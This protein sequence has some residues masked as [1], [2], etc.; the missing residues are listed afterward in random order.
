MV[1]SAGVLIGSASR[2]R[3]AV[4]LN[5]RIFTLLALCVPCRRYK[6]LDSCCAAQQHWQ[7]PARC[8]IQVHAA[9]WRWSLHA[10][11]P[12]CCHAVAG[13][14]SLARHTPSRLGVPARTAA[15]RVLVTAIVWL[16]EFFWPAA[17]VQLLWC[18][19]GGWIVPPTVPC[20]C[21]QLWYCSSVG[22]RYEQFGTE[23]AEIEAAADVLADLAYSY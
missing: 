8:C 7:L 3:G 12:H 14:V 2:P 18:L 1:G 5:P 6:Q 21:W 17:S 22:C 23:A 9:V 4:S 13:V 20:H 16:L 11:V 19:P 10:L 15:T